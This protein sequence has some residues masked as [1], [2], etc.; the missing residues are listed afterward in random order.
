MLCDTLLAP[1]P[2]QA[3]CLASLTPPTPPRSG[4]GNNG[5]NINGTNNQGL[6]IK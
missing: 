5:L 4:L 3:L 1:C 6:S 2:P